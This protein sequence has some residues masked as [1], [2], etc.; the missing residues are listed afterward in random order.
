MLNLSL[1]ELKIIAKIRGLKGYKSIFKDTLLSAPIAS[2]ST[3][4]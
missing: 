3:K 4:K 2:E 1:N